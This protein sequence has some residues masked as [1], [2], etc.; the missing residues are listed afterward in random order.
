MQNKFYKMS[1]EIFQASRWCYMQS[2]ELLG[3][4]E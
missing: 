3:E 4:T 2:D 1:R